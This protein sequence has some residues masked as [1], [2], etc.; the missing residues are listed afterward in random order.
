[1]FLLHKQHTCLQGAIRVNDFPFIAVG[2]GF[3]S[4]GAASRP[5]PPALWATPRS[6]CAHAGSS[7]PQPIT[8]FLLVAR[9]GTWCHVH[10]NHG[11]D[12][13]YKNS[14]ITIDF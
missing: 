13:S 9:L 10:E 4:H 8:N 6:R 3:N 12:N 7:V 1:M 14:P 11:E 5:D 2:Q